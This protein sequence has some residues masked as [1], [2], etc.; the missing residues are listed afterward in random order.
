M[1]CYPSIRATQHTMN[2]TYQIK[3]WI[4]FSVFILCFFSHSLV[5]KNKYIFI[6]P[7]MI[8]IFN[9]LVVCVFVLQYDCR[10]ASFL[11]REKRQHAKKNPAQEF[12]LYFHHQ[13]YLEFDYIC[14][15]QIHQQSMLFV[16]LYIFTVLFVQCGPTLSTFDQNKNKSIG[17]CARRYCLFDADMCVS[18]HTQ[19]VLS[20]SSNCYCSIPF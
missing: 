8:Y 1:W 12:G 4:V 18:K 5:Y 2:H 20:I 14:R 11:W 7:S 9:T 16:R 6:I 13:F 17:M 10:L 15:T 19:C 3:C